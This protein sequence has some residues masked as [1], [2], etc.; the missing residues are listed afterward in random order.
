MRKLV[1]L[2]AALALVALVG[3]IPEGVH[4]VAPSGDNAAPPGI[5]HTWGYDTCYW[6]RLSGPNGAGIIADHF[7]VDGPQYVE[8]K[9]SDAFFVAHGCLWWPAGGDG[10]TQFPINASHQFDDGEYLVGAE[11]PAGTY[12]ATTPASCYWA[13]VKNWTG[14]PAAII[15]SNHG[16]GTATIS[17]TDVGFQSEHCGTWTKT[18]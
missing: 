7:S 13:R 9:P 8:I 5:W 1:V 16:V 17:P 3:C 2:V 10:D 12:E 15:A 6:A 18:G 14:E 11:V 4:Q